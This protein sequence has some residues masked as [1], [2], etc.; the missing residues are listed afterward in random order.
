MIH[1]E[2]L[3]E[4]AY[5]EWGSMMAKR[6]YDIDLIEDLIAKLDRFSCMNPNA[7]YIF[8]AAKNGAENELNNVINDKYLTSERRK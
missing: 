6:L 4:K 5:F 2:L 1:E 7:S 8:S 3:R